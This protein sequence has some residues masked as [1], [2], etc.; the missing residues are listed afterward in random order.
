MGNNIYGCDKCQQACPWNK[1][2]TPTHIEELQP[3]TSLLSMTDEK[4]E[5]LDEDTYRTLF[6]DSAVKRAKYH[7]LM[8]NIQAAKQQKN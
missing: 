2:A 4:W 5:Q 6:K 8:R 7:G 1:F 3:S